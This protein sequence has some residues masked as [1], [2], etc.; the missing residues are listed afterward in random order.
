M[1]LK[2]HVALF[3]ISAGMMIDAAAH[4]GDPARLREG[5]YHTL[6]SSKTGGKEKKEVVGQR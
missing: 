3:E 2:G 1:W 5:L 6:L 4:G